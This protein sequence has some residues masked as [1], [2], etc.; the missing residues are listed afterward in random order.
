L[1]V[2]YIKCIITITIIFPLIIYKNFNFTYNKWSNGY[3]DI[4][5]LK[6]WL[7]TPFILH[8]E[9]LLLE[10]NTILDSFFIE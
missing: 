7:N 8:D 3:E 4:N 5:L 10:C 1:L 6:Y 9:P 2:I